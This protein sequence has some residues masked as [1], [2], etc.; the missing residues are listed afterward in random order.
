MKRLV[1]I[2]ALLVLAFPA[3]AQ[4]RVRYMHEMQ[5]QK[6]LLYD[7]IN[8]MR[9]FD[10]QAPLDHGPVQVPLREAAD[11]HQKSMIEYGY[12]QPWLRLNAAIFP[13]EVWLRWFI[14]P[15]FWAGEI[16]IANKCHGLPFTANQVV[17]RIEARPD[18]WA[19][20]HNPGFTGVG[21]HMRRFN[22][23]VGKWKGRGECRQAD[24]VFGP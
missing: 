11:M 3:V 4:S 15:Q 22:S 8:L 9:M 2:L 21:I 12:Q 18:T 6:A 1:L 10:G 5:Y 17:K 13:I 7:R 24:I 23:T 16:R 20:L 14:P 19:I